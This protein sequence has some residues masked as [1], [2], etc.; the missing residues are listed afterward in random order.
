M[1][2]IPK[3]YKLLN[4]PAEPAEPNSFYCV[5]P[6]PDV[7]AEWYVT[8]VEGDLVNL[9]NTDFVQAIID[10]YKT[11]TASILL[12]STAV[13]LNDGVG[14]KQNLYTVPASS[15]AIITRVDIDKLS[16]APTIA[17][18]TMGWNEDSNNTLDPFLLSDL[19]G[20]E[21]KFGSILVQP[22]SWLVGL[23]EQVLGLI[24]STPEGSAL[25][26]RMNVFGYLTDTLGVP[27]ANV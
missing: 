6:T 2:I 18:F 11:N 10:S 8:S 22:T 17:E 13:N 19:V 16:A 7:P 20:V 1:R 5:Q 12:S 15:R 9:G 4:P 26:A 21:T 24:V 14:A 23:E 25:T 27:I 3:F